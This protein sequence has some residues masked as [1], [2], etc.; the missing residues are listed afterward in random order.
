MESLICIDKTIELMC[1][2][3]E[4]FSAYSDRIESMNRSQEAAATAAHVH[5][6]LACGVH[7]VV[8]LLTDAGDCVFL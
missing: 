5:N 7:L 6:K 2:R 8:L 3:G 1:I 4:L